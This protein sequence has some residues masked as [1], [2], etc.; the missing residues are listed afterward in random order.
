MGSI[1]EHHK[2]TIDKL[3]QELEESATYQ[4]DE[5]YLTF[6]KSDQNYEEVHFTT[7]QIIDSTD[8][9]HVSVTDKKQENRRESF[10]SQNIQKV[11][12]SESKNKTLIEADTN[13]L[14]ENKFLSQIDKEKE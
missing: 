4:L 12:I 6:D 3:I 1:A 11:N 2:E 9:E 8:L 13:K 5:E 10:S 7:E 14:N